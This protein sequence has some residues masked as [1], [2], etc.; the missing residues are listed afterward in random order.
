MCEG[1]V[2]GTGEVTLSGPLWGALV[3]LKTQRIGTYFSQV[4]PLLVKIQPSGQVGWLFK[5]SKQKF[6]DNL[7]GPNLDSYSYGRLFGL[8]T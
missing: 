2:G 3:Q 1:L 8:S 6:A 7:P 4:R 5:M